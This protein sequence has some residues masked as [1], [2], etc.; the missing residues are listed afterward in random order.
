MTM[1]Q[2]TKKKPTKFGFLIT[3]VSLNGEEDENQNHI[4]KYQNVP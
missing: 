2:F 3:L 1:N 4:L